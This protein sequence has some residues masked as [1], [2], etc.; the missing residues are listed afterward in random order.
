[1]PAIKTH[2]KPYQVYH[3][4]ILI[5]SFSQKSII[6]NFPNS[7]SPHRFSKPTSHHRIK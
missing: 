2:M 6:P 1:M 4:E 3:T 7:V 5:P